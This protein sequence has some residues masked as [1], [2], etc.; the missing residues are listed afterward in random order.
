MNA[1]KGEDGADGFNWGGDIK[2]LNNENRPREYGNVIGQG[3]SNRIRILDINASY[4]LLHNLFVE[5]SYLRRTSSIHNTDENL[6]KAG[7]RWNIAD[8]YNLF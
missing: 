7:I 6:I 8:N 1:M 2:K 5:A 4:M 3:Y